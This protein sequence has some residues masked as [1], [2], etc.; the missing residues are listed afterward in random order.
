MVYTSKN[1]LPQNKE[2]KDYCFLAGSIDFSYNNWREIV[3]EE[4]K[5]FIHFF[6]PTRIDHNELNNSQMEEHIDWELN[7]MN[8][9]DTILLNFLPDFKSPISLVE[10]GLYVKSNK[11]IVVCP[12]QFYQKRYVK[13]LCEKYD[14]PF[15]D[16]LDKAI[17]YLTINKNLRSK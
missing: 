3:M 6:D 14:T 15:F 4:M 12:A 17:K 16:N 10:L 5:G 2:N 7:A 1:K 8:L 11:L 13:V 9:S